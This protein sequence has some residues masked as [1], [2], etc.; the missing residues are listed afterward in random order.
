LNGKFKLIPQRF[1]K[2]QSTQS[3]LCESFVDRRGG[4]LP[5]QKSAPWKWSAWSYQSFNNK[6][7]SWDNT[8]YT[9]ERRSLTVT[10]TD[11]RSRHVP[12]PSV[13]ATTNYQLPTATCLLH[14]YIFLY[15]ENWVG[16]LTN[17][18]VE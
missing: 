8:L 1:S 10:F 7:H 5:K 3:P 15:F 14:V 6:N 4:S 13:Y 11:A 12:F 17:F 18:V 16:L 9:S 2:T